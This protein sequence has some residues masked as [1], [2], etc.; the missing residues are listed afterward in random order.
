MP[1]DSGLRKEK[2]M[3]TS[4]VIALVVL[5]AF[6][7]GIFTG[8]IVVVPNGCSKETVSGSGEVVTR[9]REVPEFERVLLKGSGRVILVRGEK[10]K[11][12]IKTDENIQ[13]LVQTKVRGDVLEIS[14]ENHLLKP[15]ALEIQLSMKRLRGV[16]INGSGNVSG[17]STFEADEF[18]AEINGSGKM[19]LAIA[20][21]HLSTVING[22]GSVALSGKAAEHQATISGSGDIRAFDLKSQTASISIS[23]A[24]DCSLCT[25]EFL[26]AC[27]SGSGDVIYTGN[28][29]VESRVKGSGSV[30]A[31]R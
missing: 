19:D 9:T 10:Q 2:K 18:R 14:H 12:E 30:K 20:A 3:N 16:S 8:C 7:L 24:G 11:V 17:Q 15:T 27:I 25:S 1:R 29:R 13:P 4:K 5:T 21:S 22:S 26:T 6:F 31:R 28:P 23:G